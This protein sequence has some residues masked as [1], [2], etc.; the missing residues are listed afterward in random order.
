[1]TDS[2]M[3]DAALSYAARGLLVYPLRPDSKETLPNLVPHGFKDATTDE[4]Q[5]KKWGPRVT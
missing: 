2:K 3:L 5:T 1:M 4:A